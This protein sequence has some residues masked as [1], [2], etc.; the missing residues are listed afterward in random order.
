VVEVRSRYFQVAP[1]IAV[2]GADDLDAVHD[3]QAGLRV[4][5]LDRWGSSNEPLPAGPPMRPIRR[6]GTATPAE[7]MFFEELCARP[8]RT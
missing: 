4:T 7:L 8:S 6:P 1:H 2:T 5:R 3:L